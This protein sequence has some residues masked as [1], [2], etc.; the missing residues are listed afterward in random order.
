ME[1]PV[2]VQLV[3]AQLLPLH[4]THAVAASFWWMGLLKVMVFAAP[5]LGKCNGLM[6][7][8]AL[9]IDGMTQK[10]WLL[11]VSQTAPVIQQSELL[12]HEGVTSMAPP[13]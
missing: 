4:F 7:L 8:L 6:G 10:H 3:E 12:V 9:V 13:V 2:T 11:L 1:A 5:F